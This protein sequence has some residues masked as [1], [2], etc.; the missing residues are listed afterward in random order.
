MYKKKRRVMI[1]ISRPRT[2]IKFLYKNFI[3]GRERSF[4]IKKKSTV[5]QERKPYMI[6]RNTAYSKC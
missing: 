4:L 6:G 5:V 1:K 3:R 2:V